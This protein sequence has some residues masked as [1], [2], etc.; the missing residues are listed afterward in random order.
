MPDHGRR[1]ANWTL[2]SGRACGW[3][4]SRGRRRRRWRQSCGCGG[5]CGLGRRCGGAGV[6]GKRGK[7]GEAMLV[8]WANEVVYATWEE[9]REEVE[10]AEAEALLHWERHGHRHWVGSG[11]LH[12]KTRQQSG[13]SYPTSIN[14]GSHITCGPTRPNERRIF[15]PHLF[16]YTRR[17]PSTR[18][19]P[20]NHSH[21]HRGN[22]QPAIGI[23][24]HNPHWPSEDIS[25]L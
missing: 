8:E 16:Y 25:T 20:S 19:T 10:R 23:D 9:I 1:W 15:V 13:T 4:H 6:G 17:P 11:A 2:G 3:R 5:Q 21:H 12:W 22:G 7:G 14:M 24:A 18:V